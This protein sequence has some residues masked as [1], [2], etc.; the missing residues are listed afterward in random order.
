MTA[1][2]SF[3]RLSAL[4]A[5]FLGI[6]T[7]GSH[8]QIGALAVFGMGP[9]RE[10]HGGV[11][12][13]RLK[14]YVGAALDR[15]PRYRQRLMHAP[16]FGQPYWIDDEAFHLDYHVRHTAL[17]RPGDERQLKRL[18]GRIFSQRLDPT[19]PL[20]ELWI[21]EGL[22]GDRFAMVLKAHH[23]LAD[24]V[25]GA[26]ILATL[27]MGNSK[28]NDAPWTPRP[29]PTPRALL[30]AELRHRG[31][32]WRRLGRDLATVARDPRPHLGAARKLMTGAVRTLSA[33][34][35]PADRTPLN[36]D[37]VS[38]HRRFDGCRIE[39]GAMKKVKN[40]LGGTINDVVLATTA[41]ALRRTFERQ[42]V[43]ADALHDVRALVPVNTRGKAHGKKPGAGTGNS[44]ALLLAK[45]PLDVADPRA[46]YERVMAETR[47][48]KTQ[49]QNAEVTAV[50]ED[51]ADFASTGLA[52]E[53]MKLATRQR[54]YNLV[55]TNVPGPPFSLGLLGAPMEAIYPLV[56]LYENQALGI[57]LLSYAGGMF[58]GFDA[59]WT[60]L[61][62]LHLLVQDVRA[63]FAELLA[64]ARAEEAVRESQVP[65]PPDP[66]ADPEPTTTEP[67]HA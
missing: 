40:A 21:V 63:S 44:V 48:A 17:P 30:E 33:G 39:L 28:A 35:T 25:A 62:E 52:V 2:P 20:W 42:G 13:A 3:E 43:L 47:Y 50:F 5:S 51:V 31:R 65:P 18:A 8:L 23:C 60:Q 11:D 41:G 4:D 34:A 59:D 26:S 14:E 56:P 32:G 27:L 29:A 53:L 36:P 54:S 67:V 7:P 38:P 64:L 22:S 58:W 15:V 19:R 10:P 12:F 66:S 49:S 16:L 45:L 55:V 61:P 1:T 24:G 46:R 57:A 6:E 9:L 37:G